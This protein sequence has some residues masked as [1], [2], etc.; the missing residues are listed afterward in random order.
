MGFTMLCS[1]VE[2][3]ELH[4]RLDVDYRGKKLHGLGTSHPRR[5]CLQRLQRM[6]AEG[7]IKDDP[8]L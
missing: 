6:V 7:K 8:G 3:M 5:S 4:D 1:L 2:L